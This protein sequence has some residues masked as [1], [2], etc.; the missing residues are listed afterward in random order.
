MLPVKE[1][2]RIQ[3][4]LIYTVCVRQDRLYR[5]KAVVGWT[6]RQMMQTERNTWNYT[7]DN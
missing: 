5:G 1:G 4:A 6:D 7:K 2:L 3:G